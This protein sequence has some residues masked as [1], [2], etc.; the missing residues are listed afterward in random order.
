MK[1]RIVKKTEKKEIEKITTCG[2]LVTIVGTTCVF[3][4]LG[5][6]SKPNQ[7]R[8]LN[9]IDIKT[10]TPVTRCD[11]ICRLATKNEVK[12]YWDIMANDLC[13]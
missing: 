6:D 2:T 13:K 9:G 3:M 8:T 12:A 5:R 4:S 1:K 10:R 11:G 7:L